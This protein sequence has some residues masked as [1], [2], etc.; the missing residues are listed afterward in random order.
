M[1]WQLLFLA[2]VG[3]SLAS[4]LPAN[5]VSEKV[6]YS[7]SGADDVVGNGFGCAHSKSAINR[8]SS[9]ARI[10]LM[11]STPVTPAGQSSQ[12]G[13]VKHVFTDGFTVGVTELVF[14]V[15]GRTGCWLTISLLAAK[16]P[17]KPLFAAFQ[18]P[19][20]LVD[21]LALV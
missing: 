10:E 1:H 6:T 7:A 15:R 20:A 19:V 12:L 9:S 3:T 2:L 5:E 17:R 14:A 4:P 13:C 16:V 11:R 18:E 21:Q 8:K